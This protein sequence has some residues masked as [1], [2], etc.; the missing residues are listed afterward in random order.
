LKWLEGEPQRRGD[1]EC[2][3]ELEFTAR[4]EREVG[5]EERKGLGELGIGGCMAGF[6]VNPL[7]G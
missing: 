6:K 4:K 2:R 7:S 5:R 1:A 3:G